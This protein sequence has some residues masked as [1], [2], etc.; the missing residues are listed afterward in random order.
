MNL[1]AT[2]YLDR[3]KQKNLNFLVPLIHDK[4]GST[5]NMSSNL[6]QEGKDFPQNNIPRI[7]RFFFLTFKEKFP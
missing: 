1:L 2:R 3:D 7:Y 4:V 6:S 5:S